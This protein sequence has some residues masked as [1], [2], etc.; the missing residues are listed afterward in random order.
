[1][2][3]SRLCWVKLGLRRQKKFKIVN[4]IIGSIFEM[5]GFK[6]FYTSGIGFHRRWKHDFKKTNL[7]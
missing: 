7:I 6:N 2:D 5:F 4:I 1:M 3:W